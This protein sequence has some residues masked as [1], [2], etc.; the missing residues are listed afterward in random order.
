MTFETRYGVLNTNQREAVDEIS[1]NLLVIAGPGTGKT[2]LLS[3]RVANILEQTDTLPSNILCLTFTDSASSNMRQRLRDII[4]EEAHRVAIHTFHSFGVEV[5]NQNREYFFRGSEFKPADELSRHQLIQSIFESLDWSN[6]LASRNNGD[7]VYLNNVITMISEFKKSGLTVDE[8]RNIVLSNKQIFQEFNPY[9]TEVFANRVSKSTIPQFAQLSEKISPLSQTNLPDSVSL[10]TKSLIDSLVEA[11]TQATETGKTNSITAWKTNWCK[12]DQIGQTVLIDSLNVDKLLASIDI[13]REYQR[14]LA[15]AQ[16]YDY[17]DMILN[18]IQAINENPDLRANIQEQFQFIMVDEFQDTNLAQLRL[19]FSIV[20]KNLTNVM[21]VGDDDQAIYSFQG[22]DV[23]NIQRFRDFF[24]NPRIITLTDNYRSTDLII[25][26]ARS[27]IKKGVDR[28]ENTISGISKELTAWFEHPDTKVEISE[29][30]TPDS[31]KVGLIDDILELI[32]QGAQPEQIAVLARKHNE[33]IE[34]LPYFHDSNIRVNYLKR[35]NALDHKIIQLLEKLARVV[36]ALRSNDQET[37]NSLLPEIISHPAFNFQPI[38]IW[39]LSL[40]AYRNKLFWIE[41]MLASPVFQPIASWFIELA[42]QPPD[43]PIEEEFSELLGFPSDKDDQGFHS[44]LYNYYFSTDKLAENPE[45][46]LDALEAFRTIRDKLIEHFASKSPDLIDFIELIDLYRQSNEQL[47]VVRQMPDHQVGMVNLMSVHSAKG[48]EFDHV[49]IIGATDNN[50]G[51]KAG[52]RSRLIRYPINLPLEPSGNSY[53]ERLRLFFVAMT[54]ARKTL[55]ISY[56]ATTNSQKSSLLVGFIDDSQVVKRSPLETI[57]LATHAL[58]ID[59]RAKL[60]QPV[61]ANLK[62]LLAPT[63]ERYKLSATHLNNFIDLRSGGP[64]GFLLN[65]LLQLPQ[66]RSASTGYGTAIHSTLQ[67]THRHFK[68]E[69]AM[70]TIDIIIEKFNEALAKMRLSDT[71]LQKFTDRG[72]KTLEAYLDTKADT[73][74]KN[75]IAELDFA[76]Q[77]VTLGAKSFEKDANGHPVKGG[78]RHPNLGNHVTV[79]SNA[80]ILGGDTEIGDNC[81]IGGN[82]WLIHSVPAGST[83]YYN[84]E[85][86]E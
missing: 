35:D 24:V 76:N 41:S 52:S 66:G 61:T 60:S 16:L 44:P 23:G 4:G 81:V 10:Y 13:Y 12:K 59:W 46:Y 83:V 58:E 8:L 32:K 38:D 39:K 22:A 68:L 54:R 15:E 27:V 17:D 53:D 3:M 19:L 25:K 1:E 51:E 18:V 55:S 75:Q 26:S 86:K 14:A 33:L 37:A 49:F 20:D 48:L 72:K 6:P 79:Y 84:K 77:G 45:A 69:G 30:P 71:D 70:P 28:L 5:I 34:L 36:N 29:F 64:Q 82:V 85:T 43:G 67:Y 57:E 40:S 74:T 78:K 63:L 62:E 56:S 42:S 2:E 47:T 11:T 73:F 9:L 50:W 7:F 65:N 31:E 80:T 21:V